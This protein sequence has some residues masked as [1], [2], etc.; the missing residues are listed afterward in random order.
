MKK[1]IDIFE[2]LSRE[3]ILALPAGVYGDHDLL[4]VSE[5]FDNNDD[6]DREIAIHELI[7]RSP[8]VAETIAY[9][10]LCFQLVHHYRWKEEY[11]AALQRCYLLIAYT[12]Q[13]EEGMNRLNNRRD[14]ADT[15]L[16]A[17]EFDTGLSL[18]A[19]MIRDNPGDIW[20]YNILGMDLPDL[21]LGTLAIGV[22]DRGLALVA[23]ADPYKLKTQLED[24]R[25]E[26][27]THVADEPGRMNEVDP[28]V[29][30]GLQEAL[31]LPGGVEDAE[32]ELVPYPPPVARLLDIGADRDDAIYAEI[33]A[34]GQVLVPA[35]IQLAYD[36]E[37]S[38][39]SVHAIAIL[40]MIRDEYRDELALLTPWL[41]QAEGDWH[42]EMLS[43]TMG[44]VGG[45]KIQ[46][47]QEIAADTNKASYLRASAT[48]ALVE[49]AQ[50]IPDQ[51]E[52][53][54][55]FFRTLLTRPEAYQASEENFI[56]RL[57]G[58][59]VDLEARELYPEIKQIFDED[60]LEAGWLDLDYVHMQWEMPR[61][62]DPK[63][64]MDGMYLPLVCKNCGRKREHFT[65]SVLVDIN[66]LDSTDEGEPSKYDAHILDHEIVCPKCGSADQYEMTAIAHL[67]MAGPD[68][69]LS[70]P[71]F[72][73]DKKPK[74]I[75]ANPRVLY[76]RSA[77]FG[78]S[79]HPLDGLDKYRRRIAVN[80][81]DALLHAKMGS[82]LRTLMR[83][84]EALEA[85]RYAYQLDPNNPEI[86]IRLAFSEHD[87]GDR[88]TARQLYQKFINQ[89]PNKGISRYMDDYAIGAIEG[90]R[91]LKRNR[92]S[93]NEIILQTINGE[94][95]EHPSMT[96]RRAQTMKQSPTKP[97]KKS[98]G[99]TKRGRRKK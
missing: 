73:A 31:A 53:I 72:S 71:G 36:K 57:V 52:A 21:G 38:A 16:A 67:R 47:L 80:P 25:E 45:Y 79:M 98:K 97:K 91:N 66:T 40:C 51:Y 78:E 96:W 95:V 82:L 50:R 77:V 23:E 13:H 87:L 30:A 48:T 55:A 74:K 20:P 70:L 64:R 88:E 32:D 35:L 3:Q 44:K 59:I 37:Y 58:D 83:Y 86:V 43:S 27:I 99:K 68:A 4:S 14:L 90:L 42:V 54:V 63:R 5:H 61:T 56:A 29:L 17:G 2:P 75:K 10:E 60:R 12:E 65:E 1:L 69:I 89:N 24:L 92:P 8:E 93:P 26:A 85:G 15:Y 81:N 94:K 76:F 84:P 22:L 9:S 6:R 11:L 39:G 49:R 19:Q 34:L 33:I 28:E 7:L 41:D 62:P 18:Y 46:V